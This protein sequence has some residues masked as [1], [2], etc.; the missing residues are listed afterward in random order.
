[1]SDK[2]QKPLVT[3]LYGPNPRLLDEMRQRMEALNFP[4]FRSPEASM[5]ALGMALKFR[6]LNQRD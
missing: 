6:N 5:R 4:V 3:W 2:Y 1:M